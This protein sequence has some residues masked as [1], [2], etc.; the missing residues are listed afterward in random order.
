MEKVRKIVREIVQ[1]NA[2][3]GS[4]MDF[5]AYIKKLEKKVTHLDKMYDKI[6]LMFENAQEFVASVN[7]VMESSS[8]GH[9]K[10]LVIQNLLDNYDYEK[11]RRS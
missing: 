7:A 4:E 2:D 11:V 3:M 10:L 9:E 5:Q 6:E 1:E 8:P